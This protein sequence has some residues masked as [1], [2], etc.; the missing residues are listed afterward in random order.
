[1]T[2]KRET[3]V[4]RRRLE[5]ILRATVRL[6]AKPGT[7]DRETNQAIERLLERVGPA[8]GEMDL[9]AELLRRGE[10]V[11]ADGYPPQ[12]MADSDIHGGFA[13][14]PGMDTPTEKRALR[15]AS[16]ADED[17]L[18][19]G[20]AV[21]PDD[22]DQEERDVA[23]DKLRELV[24][25]IDGAATLLAHADRDRKFLLSIQWR[26]HNPEDADAPDKCSLCESVVTKIGSDRIK[27]GY[28][29]ACYEAWRRA[30][31]PQDPVE[32]RRFEQERLAKLRAREDGAG[33]VECPHA[34]C[35]ADRRA[36]EHSHFHAPDDCPAC[37]A[38][39]EAV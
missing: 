19:A 6:L 34:C 21:K 20:R 39:R 15:L 13:Q 31:A 3:A 32:R 11:V 14:V 4:A 27:S 1:M 29:P 37:A 12:S 8:D 17:A 2:V 24:S 33:H 5:F 28:C 36:I 25:S 35:P 7:L 18:N 26:Q 38:Q 10:Y 30:G 23:A 9:L 16:E 22:F